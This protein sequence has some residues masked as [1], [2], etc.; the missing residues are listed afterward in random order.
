[1]YL[2]L[3]PLEQYLFV[4]ISNKGTEV[5]FYLENRT[6]IDGKLFKIIE[7]HYERLHLF[8]RFRENSSEI[9][10][11]L[12]NT[13]KG[14]RTALTMGEISKIILETENKNKESFGFNYWKSI[15]KIALAENEE[16]IK[17]F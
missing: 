12:V 9:I 15:L 13:I 4:D 11:E 2:D 7:N 10:T 1:L 8:N 3:L 17:G 16:F 14:S 5:R 6:K